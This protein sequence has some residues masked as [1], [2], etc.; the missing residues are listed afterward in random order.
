MG[1]LAPATAQPGVDKWPRCQPHT[2]FLDRADGIPLSSRMCMGKREVLEALLNVDWVI[3]SG[4]RSVVIACPV[5]GLLRGK[6]REFHRGRKAERKCRTEDCFYSGIL[7]EFQ[8]AK[9]AGCPIHLQKRL[10]ETPAHMAGDLT[11]A[12]LPKKGL[13]KQDLADK[14]LQNRIA[15]DTKAVH[16]EADGVALPIRSDSMSSDASVMPQMAVHSEEEKERESPIPTPPIRETITW[17]EPN[18]VISPPPLPQPS[19]RQH[20]V[21]LMARAPS[22]RGSMAGGAVEPLSSGHPPCPAKVCRRDVSPTTYPAPE[23]VQPPP[24]TARVQSSGATKSGS[25]HHNGADGLHLPTV[26]LQ[27][28]PTHVSPPIQP[29][30]D[31]ADHTLLPTFLRKRFAPQ[32][33]L[34][35]TDYAPTCVWRARCPTDYAPASDS[36]FECVSYV[37]GRIVGFSSKRDRLF[38]DYVPTFARRVDGVSFVF[39]FP[40]WL[41]RPLLAPAFAPTTL[42]YAPGG[43]VA[44]RSCLLGW[45]SRILPVLGGC[46]ASRSCL[47][48]WLS[49]PLLDSLRCLRVRICL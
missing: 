6:R 24:M 25:T 7:L 23:I 45:L 29:V 19:L 27:R 38:F 33:H 32:K 10:G 41:Y 11:N 46:V 48:G 34:L 22:R 4:I 15:Q 49:L 12:R 44:Y 39:D 1:D 35:S 21:N 40:G 36:F 37:F 43:L 17:E 26:G 13:R 18:P 9:V 14:D 2:I 31:V 47:L 42:L 28:V 3:M 20:D 16:I 8:G 5:F 30:G